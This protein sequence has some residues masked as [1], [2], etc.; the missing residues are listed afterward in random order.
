MDAFAVSVTNGL[1]CELNRKQ[2][3]QMGVCFGVFQGLM[4]LTGFFLGR[5]FA[6][7]TEAIDHYLVLILLGYI[8]G[9]MILDAIEERKQTQPEKYHFSLQIML[10]QGIATS[11]D[12]LAAGIS[13]SALAEMNIFFAI[14][15]IAVLTCLLSLAGIRLGKIFGGKLGSK[16]LFFGGA[17]LIGIGVKIFVEHVFF[18]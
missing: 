18:Q 14:T 3:L 5:A 1:C 16:A 2:I 13:F 7:Y 10:M 9:K 12:A 6:Q 11:I 15:E 4:P 17:M 8:G